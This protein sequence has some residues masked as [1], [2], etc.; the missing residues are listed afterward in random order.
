MASYS[1]TFFGSK[2]NQSPLAKLEDVEQYL[3]SDPK[4]TPTVDTGLLS[5]PRNNKEYNEKISLAE[6][7]RLRYIRL[8]R[9]KEKI[10]EHFKSQTKKLESFVSTIISDIKQLQIQYMGK[11]D[12][13]FERCL[14]IIIKEQNLSKDIRFKV[15]ESMMMNKPIPDITRLFGDRPIL[16][17]PDIHLAKIEMIWNS[18]NIFN[19]SGVHS[20]LRKQA[21]VGFKS[22]R[23][24]P[25]DIDTPS[26]DRKKSS[27]QASPTDIKNNI[28]IKIKQSK[29]DVNSK[30]FNR[31]FQ[32]ESHAY[33][34]AAIRRT[35]DESIVGSEKKIYLTSSNLKSVNVKN[36]K[37]K[38]SSKD[39]SK[40]RQV[41]D[42]ISTSKPS[43][44]W[45]TDNNIGMNH[46]IFKTAWGDNNNSIRQSMKCK[47]N[48]SLNNDNTSNNKNSKKKSSHINMTRIDNML[49]PTPP[50]RHTCKTVNNMPIFG[51]NSD[52][53]KYS[54]IHEQ[55]KH[56]KTRTNYGLNQK[57]SESEDVYYEYLKDKLKKPSKQ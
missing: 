40:G 31:M 56:Q 26:L 5:T 43:K 48:E 20:T 2:S 46:H 35:H 36:K 10:S 1:N 30:N 50:E 44:G 45:T 54:G 49:S 37:V 4:V 14:E 27:E 57:P 18:L 39:S 24:D 11:L 3:R 33:Q 25:L 38:V 15:E 8:D 7:L 53:M 19:I 52:P 41:K 28:D 23:P 42:K 17:M 34:S 12:N 16:D 6:S 22:R 9:M 32:S 47:K 55:R 29:I 13:E 51:M 21:S